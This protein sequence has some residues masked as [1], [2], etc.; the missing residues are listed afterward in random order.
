MY[1]DN[2]RPNESLIDFINRAV[3]ALDGHGYHQRARVL[4]K[5]CTDDH[6]LEEVLAIA[7]QYIDLK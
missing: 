3:E 4:S 2:I 1:I 5:Q 7:S 6:N